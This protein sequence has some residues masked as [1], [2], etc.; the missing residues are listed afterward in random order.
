MINILAYLIQKQ[1]QNPNREQII[2]NKLWNV[3]REVGENPEFIPLMIEPI[4]NA[5]MPL[6]PYV[7]GNHNIDF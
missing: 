1:I 4:E 6:L 3:I 2:I 5:I 7:D